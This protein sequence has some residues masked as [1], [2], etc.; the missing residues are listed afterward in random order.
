[1]HDSH[2]RLESQLMSPELDLVRSLMADGLRQRL[3]AANRSDL[4][5]MLLKF[6]KAYAILERLSD[7][8]LH[9]ERGRC[10]ANI[11]FC[12]MHT[13]AYE[14]AIGICKKALDQLAGG[15]DATWYW[16]ETACQETISECY[17]H[18]G[19]EAQAKKW[20]MRAAQWRE[21]ALD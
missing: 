21:E 20:N 19:Q 1:M 10:L 4:R 8:E 2:L 11:G 3:E 15:S 16:D 5:D 13:G 17:A 18:L 7:S 14:E 12:L 6:E 9:R